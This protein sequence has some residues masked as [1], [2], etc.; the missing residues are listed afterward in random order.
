M[1][2]TFAI[3]LLTKGIFGGAERRFTQ[4]FEYLSRHYPGKYYLIITQDL[5]DKIQGVFPNYPTR[6]LIPVGEKDKHIKNKTANSITSKS[7]GIKH[8]GFL[9]QIYRYLRNYRIQKSYYREIEQIREEKN[10]KCFLGVY[11]G[12]LPLYFYLMKKKRDTGII[13]CDMDSWFS[14]VL[15]KEK[16]YWYRK[17]SSF[18]YA[19]ENSD[20]IDFLSPFILEGIRYRSIKVNEDAV[21]ITPCSFADYSKCKAGNKSI[22]QVAFAGRLEKD[23]NP[24]MFVDAAIRLSK[25]YPEMI[26]HIMGEG[27]LTSDIRERV[28]D[29]GS[30]NI[31]FHGFHSTPA[32]IL[33]DT[34][35]FVSIQTTNNYPSQSVLEAMG[36][37]NAIVATDVGD[38]KMFI[39]ENNG[40]LIKLNAD[41][42]VNAIETLYLDDE[43][44]AKMGDYAYKYVRENHTVEKMAEYYVDL[45]NNTV[46]RDFN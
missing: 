46:V 39:N 16:K 27:R 42:L 18:N 40:I 28:E 31:I 5:Y 41:E 7:H 12:I 10:I 25:K 45:F 24:E 44:R 32:E 17:F 9:K 14:D 8:P 35:V 4:L 13:F 33:A 20:H 43:L 34:S 37:G 36:C 30:G 3:V 38:T 11:N 23:K 21:S 19:L 1:Q 6:Y 15:P 22:F 2:N 26:F 29:A